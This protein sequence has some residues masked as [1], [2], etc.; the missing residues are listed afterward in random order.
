M[1]VASVNLSVNETNF[2]FNKLFSSSNLENKI[3]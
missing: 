1:G 2:E 3:S